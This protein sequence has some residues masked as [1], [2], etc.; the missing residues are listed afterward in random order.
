M[1]IKLLHPKAEPPRKA[2][3][4]DNG[5]DLKVTGIKRKSLFKVHYTFGIAVDFHINGYAE[6]FSRSSIHKRF[7]WLS[8]GVGVIDSGYRGEW[9]AVFYKIPFLSKPYKIGEYACQ[10][11][12]KTRRNESF[13]I[14]KELSD[15]DRGVKGYGSSGI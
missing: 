13:T 7:L 1:N 11:L 14:V 4:S 15:S 2:N 9:Q 6:V 8:N 5:Y 10:A 3:E 12:F